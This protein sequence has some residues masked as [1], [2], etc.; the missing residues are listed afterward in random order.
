MMPYTLSDDGH[1]QNEGKKKAGEDPRSYQS[2]TLRNLS[3]IAQELR[4]PRHWQ[5]SGFPYRTAH[6]LISKCWKPLAI[7]SYS[8]W[9]CTVHNWAVPA[10]FLIQFNQPWF[11]EPRIRL[12]TSNSRI[13]FASNQPKLVPRKLDPGPS[14]KVGVSYHLSEKG[15]SLQRVHS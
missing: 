4:T 11:G 14:S 13:Q 3:R 8:S 5:G 9:M 10:L 2:W 1:H 6:W 15:G 7:A 12:A